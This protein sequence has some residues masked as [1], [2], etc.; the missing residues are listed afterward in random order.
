MIDMHCSLPNYRVQDCN[1][2][3]CALCCTFWADLF[4]PRGLAELVLV[5]VGQALPAL[6][7]S[8]SRVWLLQNGLAERVEKSRK[9]IKERKNRSKKIRGVKKNAG[10]DA[11]HGVEYDICTAD[12]ACF[13]LDLCHNLA[14]CVCLCLD[15]CPFTPYDLPRSTRFLRALAFILDVNELTEL[16][17]CC[18]VVGKK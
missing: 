9:Q 5:L 16:S 17:V 18:T 6:V 3:F 14:L 4:A 13:P 7:S 12:C 10:T 2:F 1:I 11:T 8:E 15:L